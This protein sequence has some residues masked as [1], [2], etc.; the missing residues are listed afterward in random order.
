MPAEYKHVA[1]TGLLS[2]RRPQISRHGGKVPSAWTRCSCTIDT[3]TARFAARPMKGF[4]PMAAPKSNL[5]CVTPAAPGSGQVAFWLSEP[6]KVGTGQGEW[7]F[8]I[9]AGQDV[10]LATFTY[11]SQHAASRAREAMMPVL[12]EATGIATAES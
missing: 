8:A 11:P 3:A 4:V 5:T 9:Y 6:E 10:L 2:A 1:R 12:R 7:G